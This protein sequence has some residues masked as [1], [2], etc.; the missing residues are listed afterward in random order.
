M[1][2]QVS[3]SSL[4]Q[5]RLRLP[6]STAWLPTRVAMNWERLNPS[7]LLE[8]IL[9][10]WALRMLMISMEPLSILLLNILE[11]SDTLKTSL[12]TVNLKPFPWLLQ[13]SFSKILLQTML[14]HLFYPATLKPCS[15]YLNLPIIKCLLL[16]ISHNCMQSWSFQVHMTTK[17]VNKKQINLLNYS[18][19]QINILRLIVKIGP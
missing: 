5:I 19:I 7:S 1:W 9:R 18:K 6:S 4:D 2:L 15:R 17:I 13:F 10:V 12:Q 11:F 8:L 16:K 3:Y 14:W